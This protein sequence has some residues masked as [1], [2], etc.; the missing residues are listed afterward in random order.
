LLFWVLAGLPARHLGGGDLALIHAGTAELLCLAPAVITL[1]WATRLLARDPQQTPILVLGATG[2]RLFGVLL[3]ALV[4]Y[5]R[6]PPFREQAAFLFWVLGAYLYTLA[7]EI[8]LLLSGQP[9]SR[10]TTPGTKDA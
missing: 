7:V 2:I 5:L 4:L 6:V 1:V 3:A 8:A 9:R 10:P